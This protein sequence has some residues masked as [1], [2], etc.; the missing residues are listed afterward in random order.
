M[1]RTNSLYYTNTAKITFFF[2]ITQISFEHE[3]KSTFK[4][5][6]LADGLK[7]YTFAKI[8][9]KNLDLTDKVEYIKKEY[10]AYSDSEWI[11]AGF[12]EHSGGYWV[13]HK[14]HRFD[15]TKG[16]FGIPRGDYER[17]SSEILM[18]YSMRVVLGSEKQ[19]GNKNWEK[20]PDGLLND[21]LFD[22]KGV[23]G[24]GKENILKDIKDASKKGCETVVLY[25]HETR[26][27]DEKQIR[28]NYQTYMRNSKSKRVQQVYY[29][30]DRKLYT[31]K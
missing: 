21:K 25:Y 13:Y 29:I 14:E 26:L 30:V 9:I 2:R 5:G 23:E 6:N 4:N 10:D 7:F 12:D 3:K 20:I 31:L 8:S 28:D 19:R 16:I 27:F 1:P 22:I 11:K 24:M 18:N 17:I 15:P